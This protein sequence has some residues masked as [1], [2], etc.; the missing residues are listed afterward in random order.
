MTEL[1]Q[2]VTVLLAWFRYYGAAGGVRMILATALFCSEMMVMVPELY[3]GRLS[4]W[5]RGW[6]WLSVAAV[7]VLRWVWS[8]MMFGFPKNILVMAAVLTLL[9]M[10]VLRKNP[11][12][13]WQMFFWELCTVSWL[14]EA[15]MMGVEL[16]G[17]ISYDEEIYVEIALSAVLLCL[18]LPA[19]FWMKKKEISFYN[20]C[21]RYWSILI[22]INVTEYFLI[23]YGFEG[24]PDLNG[25]LL[26][27]GAVVLTITGILL[28]FL[29]SVNRQMLS[30]KREMEMKQ[31][32]YM[33]MQEKYREI[34]RLNHDIK[35]ERE[36]LYQSLTGGQ[37]DEAVRYLREK[38][39][40]QESGIRIITHLGFVDAIL[41]RKT[42]EME[43]QNIFF[44]LTGEITRSPIREDEFGVMLD[45]L[46]D[47]A[48]EA[49][50]QCGEGERWVHLDLTEQNEMCR[51]CIKNASR[52]KPR[53]MNGAFV[54]SKENS[55]AHG[56]GLQNVEAIVRKYQGTIK[57]AYSD[58]EFQVMIVFWKSCS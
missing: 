8:A 1:E 18:F 16:P 42:G 43:E 12:V 26:N 22:F 52:Q 11:G 15:L 58:R 34:A 57:Y 6:L 35:R 44:K 45:N 41:N 23:S 3:D 39:Q 20:I 48:L 49:A 13:L 55:L 31:A 2:N 30:E 38:Q 33:E 4:P 10:P 46:L 40:S 47:N 9:T 7:S 28:M 37:V 54:T 29:W 56:W 36:Y 5:K 53:V 32:Y 19:A 25:F 14:K 21:R 24:D 50:Q 17:M 51:I 27:A